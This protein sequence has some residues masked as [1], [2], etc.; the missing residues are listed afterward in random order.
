MIATIIGV[1]LMYAKCMLNVCKMYV[2]FCINSFISVCYN[3]FSVCILLH[4][5]QLIKKCRAFCKNNK[6]YGNYKLSTPL[7]VGT[8]LSRPYMAKDLCSVVPSGLF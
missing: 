3:G 4:I 8:R 1:W 6:N 5:K 7:D 2:I